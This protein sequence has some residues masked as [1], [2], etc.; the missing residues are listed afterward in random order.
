MRPRTAA[1]LR[2]PPS[3]VRRTRA[4]PRRRFTVERA[5]DVRR[6]PA[7]GDSSQPRTDTSSGAHRPQFRLRRCLCF[8][9]GLAG[10]PTCHARDGAGG[11][12]PPSDRRDTVRAASDPDPAGVARAVGSG[13]GCAAAAQAGRRARSDGLR[14]RHT[15]AASRSSATLNARHSGPRAG[16]TSG[17]KPG[18]RLSRRGGRMDRCDVI[19][20][21]EASVKLRQAV[22]VEVKNSHKFVDH[23]KDVVTE[24]I[25]PSGYS[26]GRDHDRVIVD[27]I[28]FCTLGPPSS[29]SYEAK[30][31]RPPRRAA[32]V[33]PG[34]RTNGLGHP[35]HRSR[36][37]PRSPP[38][39]RRP[40]T[41]PSQRALRPCRWC[42]RARVE[43]RGRRASARL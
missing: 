16:P 23:A 17:F 34:S 6:S 33:G 7:R 12:P 5:T 14:I 22:T 9:N 11:P 37:W 3:S 15:G 31:L 43:D 35:A 28:G 20:V 30:L 25:A 36:P 10:H 29:S 40:P 13:S 18:G 26:G 41:R 27:D 39:V 1:R 19:D 4:F 8:A 32:N 42:R 21:L 24:P 38:Y 2:S